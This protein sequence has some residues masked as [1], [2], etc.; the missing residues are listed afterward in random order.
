MKCERT[1][2]RAD[3]IFV[4]PGILKCDVCGELLDA[5]SLEPL[6][7]N[8]FENVVGEPEELPWVK[9]QDQ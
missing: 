3:V 2:K 5:D 8:L 9:E 1:G 7:P 4:Q 6:Q